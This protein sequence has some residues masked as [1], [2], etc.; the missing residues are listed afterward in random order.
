MS[1]IKRLAGE[2]ALYGLGSIVPRAIN[3][4]LVVLHTNNMFSAAEYGKITIILSIVAFFN[5]FYSFGMETAYFRFANKE[6]LEEKTIFNLAHTA[7]IL[8]SAPISVL[9]ILFASHLSAAI[10]MSG[11]RM[12]ITW[13][14]LTLFVD[15]LSVIPFA[16]LRLQKKALQFALI[17]IV[18][19]SIQVG[20]N[21]Y[22]LKFNYNPSIGI[23]YVF[24][25]NLIA[26][27]FY[28][29]FL[30]KTLTTWRPAF[31]KN[32]SP[33]M[34]SYAYPV[35]L[36][37]LA[38]MTNEMFSRLTLEK[39]L[40]PNFYKDISNAAAMG[41]FGACYKFAVL[42]NL[43]IQAFRYAAEPFFFSNA[44]EKN[45]P[46]LF[47][48]VNHY[49]VVACCIFLFAI[50]V[51]ID[52]IKYLIGEEYWPGLPIVPILLL[53]YLFLGVYYNFSVWFKL[54]DQTYFGT[55]ITVV[56]AVITI[57]ANYF[58]IPIWGYMGSSVAA[59]VCY[60]AMAAICYAIGQTKY[61][62][63]YKV[64]LD[65]IWILLTMVLLFA[66]QNI[67]IENL[68]LNATLHFLLTILFVAVVY[69]IERK[70][71]QKKEALG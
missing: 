60:F 41:I 42:M 31:D 3:F 4:L 69:F 19:I 67:V 44:K 39:W 61:P 21:I 57:V 17:R 62:I 66:V 27:L 55:I 15:A 24:L 35:M 26:N 23:G 59:L 70:G 56:G 16:R 65:S 20:L 29:I 22:F 30:F 40:P 58:L 49:F 18:V 34:L 53:A 64:G 54:T 6:G 1:K 9:I 11:Q 45:S 13:V 63:P 51:N 47:A 48:R 37:G 10:D 14:S 25:A 46:E 5:V 28:F 71:L 52:V 50:S 38:G 36:T 8:V 2:T 12:L 33:E 43:G 7:V 32:I 68:F